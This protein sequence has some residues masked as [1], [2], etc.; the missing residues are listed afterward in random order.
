[1]MLKFSGSLWPLRLLP[2][3]TKREPAL[4]YLGKATVYTHNGWQIFS[5]LWIIPSM[6]SR[7]LLFQNDLQN[8]FA[9]K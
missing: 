2:K 9:E 7:C 4:P 8:Q 3:E 5:Q 6:L 1:M